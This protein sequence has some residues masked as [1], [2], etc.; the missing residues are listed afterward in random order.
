MDISELER[1]LQ[2]TQDALEHERRELVRVWNNREVALANLTAV[3]ERCNELLEELRN[4]RAA[5]KMTQ[6][7]ADF[8][9]KRTSALANA[10]VTTEEKLAA[11]LG[12]RQLELPC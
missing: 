3:Q 8:W 4:S 5:H 1:R 11:A 2:E 9:R 10:L 12:H 6:E 7:E